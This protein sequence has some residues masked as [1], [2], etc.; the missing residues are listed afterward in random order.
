MCLFVILYAFWAVFFVSGDWKS[1]GRHRQIWWDSL[2]ILHTPSQRM[3]P[4]WWWRGFG[5]RTSALNEGSVALWAN[6]LSSMW[7]R[8][9]F[10]ETLE[11]SREVWVICRMSACMCLYAACNYFYTRLINFSLYFIWDY[12]CLSFSLLGTAS[13]CYNVNDCFGS[14]KPLKNTAA[15]EAALKSGL[16]WRR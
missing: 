5:I 16:S 9:D 3:W 2:E 12:I 10:K 4:C 15:S 6:A 1:S 8:A 13:C 11:K 14:G 7:L